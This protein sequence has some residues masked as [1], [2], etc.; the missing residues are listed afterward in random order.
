MSYL[1]SFNH[2]IV[3]Y[4]LFPEKDYI[5]QY[6]IEF[7]NIPMM[8]V[9]AGINGIGKTTLLKSIEVYLKNEKKLCFNNHRYTILEDL[10]IKYKNDV[11][12]KCRKLQNYVLRRPTKG[13]VKEDE[14][15][16]YYER[17]CEETIPSSDNEYSRSQV[18][19]QICFQS[20]Q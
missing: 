7:I 12:E 13:F 2:E 19:E 15:E 9:I 3:K 20:V 17:L 4:I 14:Y 18:Y 10:K 8:T 16:K 5:E 11:Y 6:K 1:K